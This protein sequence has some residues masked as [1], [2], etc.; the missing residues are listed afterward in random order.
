MKKYLLILVIALVVI[1]AVPMMVSAQDSTSVIVSGT[2][3]TSFE[4]TADNGTVSFPAFNTG[5]NDA[6]PTL[7]TITTNDPSWTVNAADEKS[8]ATGTGYMK[9]GSTVLKDPFQLSPNEDSY[10]GL[11]YANIATGSGSGT[12]DVYYSQNI[13]STDLAGSY[14]ITVDFNGVPN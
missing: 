3:S 8:P 6:G 9:S 1:L 14:N 7:L 12:Q 10:K 5:E 4:L 11:P 13:E 2:L